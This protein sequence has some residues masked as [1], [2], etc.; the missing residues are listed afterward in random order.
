[1]G[2]G[3]TATWGVWIGICTQ[4]LLTP[5]PPPPH[6]GGTPPARS[7]SFTP[8]SLQACG[9]GW[10]V[11]LSGQRREEA[12]VSRASNGSTR[13]PSFPVRAPSMA[14]RERRGRLPAAAE[15][16]TQRSLTCS[17]PALGGVSRAG[18]QRPSLWPGSCGVGE[19]AREEGVSSEETPPPRSN[20]RNPPRRCHLG[21]WYQRGVGGR[22]SST[23]GALR[24]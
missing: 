22:E 20:D 13:C 21:Y 23:R 4:P 14:G 17:L 5:H 9:L 2:G 15:R 10:E 6:L 7:C 11:L 24:V 3:D 8:R 18:G 1:M 12:P 16:H 19:R